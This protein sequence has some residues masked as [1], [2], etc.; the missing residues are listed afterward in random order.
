MV[1]MARGRKT[2]GRLRQWAANGGGARDGQRR[3]LDG[4]KSKKRRAKQRI[5]FRSFPTKSIAGGG[6]QGQGKE[7]EEGEEEESGPFLGSGG[8]PSLIS[9]EHE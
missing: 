5:S 1:V 7:G 9:D 3:C 4:E 8:F 2:G 6:A